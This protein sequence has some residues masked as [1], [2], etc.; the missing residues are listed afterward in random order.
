MNY[1][2]KTI[3]NFD[4]ID[5]CHMNY[6]TSLIHMNIRS[7]RKNFITFLTQ[8]NNILNKIHLIILT[9]TNITDDENQFYSI[10][11]Y[12]AIFINRESRGGGIAIYTKENISFE[13]H[14][15]NAI[16]YES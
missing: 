5:E 15:T 6:H 1:S 3:N 12:N 11:G 16:S 4:E 2:F 8:I 7:P 9:E 10:H 13:T 14:T